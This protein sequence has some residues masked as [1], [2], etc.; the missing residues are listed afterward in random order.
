MQRISD[1]SV[2]QINLYI[3]NRTDDEKTKHHHDPLKFM[4][5]DLSNRPYFE[6]LIKA[7]DCK[8]NDQG[9]FYALSIFL[10]MT[11]NPG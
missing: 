1:A 7:L 2:K 8:E 11:M 4:E 3:S 10:T 9:C 5:N 6:A